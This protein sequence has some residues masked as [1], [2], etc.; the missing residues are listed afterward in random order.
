MFSWRNNNKKN[1]N[2]FGLKKSILLRAMVMFC[3]AQV[4]RILWVFLSLYFQDATAE[5]EGEFDEEEA[6][7][8]EN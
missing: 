3:N 8:E 1:I 4:F 7:G 2:T 6:E 5:E